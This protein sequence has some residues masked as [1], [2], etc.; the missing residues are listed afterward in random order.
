M[1]VS[2]LVAKIEVWPH[3]EEDAAQEIGILKIANIGTDANNCADYA[4]VLK[5]GGKETWGY[6]TEFDSRNGAIQLVH[7][8]LTDLA[9]KPNSTRLS[10]NIR[11][12]LHLIADRAVRL[13]MELCLDTIDR[14]SRSRKRRG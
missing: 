5:Q 8:A 4:I 10:R 14:L 3:E 7:A 11:E 13:D 6:I 12:R 9:I 2:L 1:G